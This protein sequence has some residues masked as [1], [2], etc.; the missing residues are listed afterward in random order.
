[1]TALLL[2]AAAGAGIGGL[3]GWLARAVLARQDPVTGLPTR[4]AWTRQAR[5]I[6]RRGTHTVTLIDLDDFKAVNDTYGHPAGDH[7]LAATAARMRAWASR[8]GGAACGRLGGD[9]FTII[10]RRPITAAETAD[11]AAALADLVTLP[12]GAGTVPVS[13]SVGTAP[14]TG[15]RGLPAALAAA[16]AAMYASKTGRTGTGV[17]TARRGRG[18]G[19]AAR[20]PG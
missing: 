19:P 12:G 18:H 3:G 10:T 6:L 14:C 20:Q 9:E 11:L 7:V 8:C 5:R 1:M 2:A 4:H 16:D 15:R 13:A 17:S